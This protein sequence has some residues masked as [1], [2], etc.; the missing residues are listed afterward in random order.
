ME[1]FIMNIFESVGTLYIVPTPIGNLS[2]LSNRIIHIL[3]RV[4]TIA[5]EDTRNTLYL[6]NH[7]GIEKKLVSYHKFNEVSKSSYLIQELLSGRDIALVSDAGTPCISDPG[8]IIVRD[9]VKNN[10]NVV[11]VCGPCAAIT[12]ISISGFDTASFAFWGFFPRNEQEIKNKLKQAIYSNTNI[13]VFYESPKRIK[14]T[15]K[16]VV[17]EYPGIEICLCNDLT[18]KYEKIYRGN[19]EYVLQ[20]IEKNE[21]SEKGE[22]TLVVDFSSRKTVI[23]STPSNKIHHLESILLDYILDNNCSV[24]SAIK[25]LS[26]DGSYKR[27]DLYNAS[28]KLKSLSQEL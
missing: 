11:G 27:N 7:L 6:L 26:K 20:C 14:D 9:A 2:D 17:R 24:K 22:Y 3:S 21:F 1:D 10:I 8:Y 12:A 15:I 25:E 13:G 16:I 18:K 28:L 19:V 4:S 5:A 23:E